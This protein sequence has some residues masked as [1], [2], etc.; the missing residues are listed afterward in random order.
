MKITKLESFSNTYVSFV[1][2]TLEDGNS[3][4]GQMST[5]QAD[6]TTKIFHRQVAPWALGKHWENFE[7][8][9]NDITELCVL[10]NGLSARS[11]HSLTPLLKTI[12]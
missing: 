2:A 4:Y 8:I 1:K 5:Y 3:G 11:L 7:N 12:C 9:E 10:P 6:I